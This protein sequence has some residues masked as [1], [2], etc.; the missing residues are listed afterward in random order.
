MPL[1]AGFH[2]SHEAKLPTVIL[3]YPG[4]LIRLTPEEAETL[5]AALKPPP[6]TKPEP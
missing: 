1:P 2:L 3:A 5:A 6:L 4:G